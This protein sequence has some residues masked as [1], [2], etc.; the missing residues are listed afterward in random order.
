MTVRL[1]EN[2]AKTATRG[3]SQPPMARGIPMA[4]YTKAKKRFWRMVRTVLREISM[5]SIKRSGSGVKR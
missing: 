1:L 3:L 5:A 2:M 4:L